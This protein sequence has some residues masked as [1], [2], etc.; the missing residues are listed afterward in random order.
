MAASTASCYARR[1][2]WAERHGEVCLAFPLKLIPP[3]KSIT[4][5]HSSPRRILV[6]LAW[7]FGDSHAHP[8]A[9]ERFEVC[10]PD[11]D[12]DIDLCEEHDVD[13]ICTVGVI[14]AL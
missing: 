7:D 6:I 4:L 3:N 5:S 11:S 10:W 13:E 8:F 1:A 2:A 12:D 14:V 9:D